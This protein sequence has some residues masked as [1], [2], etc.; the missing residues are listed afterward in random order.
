VIRS[1]HPRIL[2]LVTTGSD[3]NK[4]RSDGLRVYRTVCLVA[5]VIGVAAS[6]YFFATGP[7]DVGWILAVLTVLLLP[8]YLLVA[9]TPR[10]HVV[11]TAVG[12]GSVSLHGDQVSEGGQSGE[13]V[14]VRPGGYYV[15]AIRRYK[16]V[17]DGELAGTVKSGKACSLRVD[18]GRHAIEAR[19]DWTGSSEVA[20][21]VAA[22]E[23]VTLT[24]TPGSPT[25]AFSRSGKALSLTVGR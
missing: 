14:V 25:A 5:A 22:G 8:A 15:N 7:A 9:R 13:I 18:P 11:T 6:G 19:I 2:G 3:G 1:V 23:T 16:I 17:V 12:P 4:A 10:H 24:V 21:Q 20:V